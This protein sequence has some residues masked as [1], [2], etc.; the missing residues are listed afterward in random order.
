MFQMTISKT[1]PVNALGI[2]MVLKKLGLLEEV[3]KD[4]N[5]VALVLVVPHEIADS[6]KRQEIVSAAVNGSERVLSVR[7]I[8]VKSAKK[9]AQHGITTIDE[10]MRAIDTNTLPDKTISS[11]A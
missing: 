2:I 6:Y 5:R 1:H 8:G 7:G 11:T 9:L 3:K 10:L 4:P